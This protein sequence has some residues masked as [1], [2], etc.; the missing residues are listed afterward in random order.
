M[1]VPTTEKE[2]Q[3]MLRKI[4]VGSFDELVGSI[5]EK[6]RNPAYR[7]PK[8]LTEMELARHMEALGAQNRLPLSFLGGGAQEHYIPAAVWA[9]ALRGE[10]ATAYTPYQAEASQGTLQLIYEFQ[11]MVCRLLEMEVA[12][13]SHYDGA[14]ALAE[15]VN[16][17]LLDFDGRNP[18]RRGAVKKVIFPETLHPH[19]RATL[20]T[21]FHQRADVRLECLPCPD[22]TLAPSV[23]AGYVDDSTAAVAASCPNFFGLLEPAGELCRAAHARG[24]LFIACVDPVGM[25][26]LEPPGS[27][28]A[29]LAVAEGIGLGIPPSFGG[30]SLGLVAAKRSL[31]RKM[32]GRFCGLTADRDGR[33][34]YVLTLQAREQHIR[35]EKSSSNVCTNQALC[36]TAATIHM[37][38]LGPEGLREAAELCYGLSHELASALADIPGFR[39]KFGGASFYNEFVLQCPQDASQA[40]KFLLKDDILAGYPLGADYPWLK[41]CLL[42]CATETKTRADLRRLAEAARKL[43]V[44]AAR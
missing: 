40:Q 30:P 34:G 41:D 23:L 15:A 22:G 44:A 18:G 3:E 35:R 25:G 32:P 31:L 11:S 1:F 27:Y 12:N 20:K 16:V 28:G 10:F 38:L 13:A 9:V 33:R 29:D 37:A 8:A 6:A 19:Y 17:A 36:A 5:P 43:P 21:Y 2:R 39:L 14:S 42:V 4:G 7:L 26:I 24:A